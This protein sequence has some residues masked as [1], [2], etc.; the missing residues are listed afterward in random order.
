[1]KAP[2]PIES[3]QLSLEIEERPTA[4]LPYRLRPMTPVTADT[5]FDDPDWFFEPWWPGASALAYIDGSHVR[6]QTGHLTDPLIAFP[7]LRD[8]GGQFMDDRLIVEGTLLVL[9]DDGRPDSDLLRRRLADRASRR[10][11]PAFVASDLLYERGHSIVSKSFEERRYKLSRQ[12]TDGDRCVF[13]RGIRGEGWTLAEAIA[14]MGVGEISA[15]LLSAPYRP[16]TQDDSWLRLPV[17]QT[18]AT[19]TR[20]LLALLQ[21]LPL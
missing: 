4:A 2:A 3:E 12:I 9:D 1:M 21:R 8:I 14:S 6:L 18:P 19:P 17:V 11:V 5:P 7:E 16:G 10:G 13:S 15:R 20:P